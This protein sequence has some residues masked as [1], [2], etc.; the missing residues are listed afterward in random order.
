MSEIVEE[1]FNSPEILI[2]EEK[3]EVRLF[4]EQIIFEFLDEISDDVQNRMRRCIDIIF[5]YYASSYKLEFNH[6]DSKHLICVKFNYRYES[7]SIYG[8][9][10]MLSYIANIFP[11][12]WIMGQLGAVCKKF[13][14]DGPEYSAVYLYK[15]IP[16]SGSF[17]SVNI[18]NIK[19]MPGFRVLNETSNGVSKNQV[20]S[21]N[22]TMFE[23]GET[24]FAK[25][26]YEFLVGLSK[27]MQNNIHKTKETVRVI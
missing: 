14:C 8:F 22:R 27:W 12:N 5:R 3:P 15:N 19:L 11:D 20:E 4:D 17:W 7:Q 9:I 21:F 18:S 6:A 10:S 25:K 13:M 2:P 26:K 16:G 24:F 1:I 23:V